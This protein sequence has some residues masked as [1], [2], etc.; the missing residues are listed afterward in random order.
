MNIKKL[1]KTVDIKLIHIIMV[2]MLIT[3]IIVSGCDNS[4]EPLPGKSIFG[5]LEVG[6]VSYYVG[7]EGE[8]YFDSTNINFHYTEDTLIVKVLDLDSNGFLIGVQYTE[9]STLIQRIKSGEFDSR[10][11]LPITESEFYVNIKND[12]LIIQPPHESEAFK[13]TILFG[14]ISIYYTY[15]L[16]LSQITTNKIKIRGWKT[17]VPYCECDSEGYIENFKILNNKY[18]YVNAIVDDSPMGYDASGKTFIYSQQYG[19]VRTYD[20]SWWFK[21]GTGWDFLKKYYYDIKRHNLQI[22]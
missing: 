5:N 20:V 16:P 12:S 6:N 21:T 10:S 8:D 22:N 19:I 4:I 11:H 7:F 9:G 1:K 18:S 17:S 3:L 13:Y 2:V 14:D 15:K